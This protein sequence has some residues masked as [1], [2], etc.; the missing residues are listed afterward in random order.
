MFGGLTIFRQISYFRVGEGG[1]ED[2][3]AGRQRRIPDKTFTNLDL[4]LDPGRAI[5]SR[6]YSGFESFGYFQ[7]A[8]TPSDFVYEGPTTLKVR[9]FLDFGEYNT[10][11]A[12]G[13][14]LIY[15][16]GGLGVSPEIWE[17]GLFDTANNMVAYGTFPKEVKDVTK[18]IENL[19][20]IVF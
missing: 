17:L 19:V 3:G 13:S 9:C 2:P 1:W 8:L 11:N 18:Q 4:A 7:K 10:K 14:T 16:V 15:N 12:A 6:R 5:P 20:R